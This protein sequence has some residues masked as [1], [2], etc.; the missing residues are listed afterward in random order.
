MP[1]G[2]V[3]K[4][5]LVRRSGDAV[6]GPDCEPAAERGGQDDGGGAVA[7]LVV[8]GEAAE[9]EV[10]ELAEVPLRDLHGQVGCKTAEAGLA[11]ETAPEGFRGRGFADGEG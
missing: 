9:E 2:E 1:L 3:R 10:D 4:D 7:E 5:A 6:V 11:G 8:G